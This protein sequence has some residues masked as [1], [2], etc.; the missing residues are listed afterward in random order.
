MTF[1]TQKEKEIVNLLLQAHPLK[2]IA[3]INKC[4]IHTVHTHL[5]N[6]H[7]KTETHSIPELMVW[8]TRNIETSVSY[9]LFPAVFGM[10]F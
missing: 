9:F 2:V 6:I 5:R 3:D 1:F 8:I 4:S 10:F 7:L